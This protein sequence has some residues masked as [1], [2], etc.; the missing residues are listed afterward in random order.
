MN[1]PEIKA[2]VLIGVDLNNK[3][4]SGTSLR[5]CVETLGDDLQYLAAQPDLSIYVVDGPI[6]IGATFIEQKIAEAVKD[7]LNRITI[8]ATDYYNLSVGAFDAKYPNI[9]ADREGQWIIQ[10]LES[11]RQELTGGK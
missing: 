10:Y 2:K 8:Y 7:A 6:T 3:I 1:E 9:N 4:V 11:L 5:T